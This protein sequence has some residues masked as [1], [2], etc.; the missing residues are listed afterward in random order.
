ML[1]KPSGCVQCKP[2]VA[3]RSHQIFVMLFVHNGVPME[4][5]LLLFIIRNNHLPTMAEPFV[6]WGC[7]AVDYLARDK[8]DEDGDRKKDNDK[9]KDGVGRDHQREKKDKKERRKSKSSHDPEPPRSESTWSEASYYSDDEYPP[10]S[11]APPVRRNSHREPEDTSRGRAA[12]P[13]TL[14]PSQHTTYDSATDT[15]WWIDP[16]NTM[17]QAEAQEIHEQMNPGSRPVAPPWLDSP[18][19]EAKTNRREYMGYDP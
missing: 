2:M 19:P 1:Y 9:K 5:N 8:P 3:N 11:R 17:S 12:L 18:P 10:A 7:A 4:H 13:E 6:F 16:T 15:E 14:Q